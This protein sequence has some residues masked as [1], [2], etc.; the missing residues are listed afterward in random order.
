MGILGWLFG[1]E[2][3][4]DVIAGGHSWTRAGI[5]EDLASEIGEENVSKK[6]VDEIIKTFKVYAGHE[7]LDIDYEP[8]AGVILGFEEDEIGLDQLERIRQQ[9]LDDNIEAIRHDSGI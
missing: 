7:G 9:A 3:D 4:D 6:H 8:D 2:D 5:Q 1:S